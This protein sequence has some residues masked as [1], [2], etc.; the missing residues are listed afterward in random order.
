MPINWSPHP[1]YRLYTSL[2]SYSPGFLEDRTA[3]S[4]LEAEICRR[5]GIESGVCTPMARTG[6]FLAMSELIRPGQHVVMSP[7]T[8]VDVVN[9]VILAGGVP[10]FV[11]IDRDTCGI[12]PEL[13]ESRIDSR[14]G[15]VLITHLHGQ[16]C[17][18]HDFRDICDRRGIPL[19]EDAAQA[20]GAV[21]KGN[22]WARSATWAFT[23]SGT[24]RTLPLGEEEWSSLETEHSPNV[25]GSASLECARYPELA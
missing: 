20:F 5:F 19:V 17:G 22:D 6:L 23:A 18:V 8:I 16:S 10:S 13:A 4:A 7:L 11:D 24:T 14:T 2:R 21:E 12:N 1:R 25:C 3:T 9:A 15:A